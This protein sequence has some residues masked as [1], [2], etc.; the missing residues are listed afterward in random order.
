[1]LTSISYRT[2]HGGGFILCISA[3]LIAV[4]YMERH[5]GLAPCPLCILDRVVITVIAILCLLAWLQ[6]P[7]VFGQRIYAV[8]ILLHGLIGTLLAGRHIYLQNLPADKVPNCLPDLDYMLE[9]FPVQEIL[10]SILSSAGECA[11]VSWTF[12]GMSIPQQTLLLF[13]VL[14]IIGG[15]VLFKPATPAH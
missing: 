15:T 7:S 10:S 3:L 4:F 14:S 5:L 13:I 8:L 11:T 12:M 2:L 6:N 1:M 9:T